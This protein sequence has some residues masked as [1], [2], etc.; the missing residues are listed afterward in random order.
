MG[1]LKNKASS[2]L[3]SQRKKKEK[4]EKEKRSIALG[5][6]EGEKKRDLGLIKL[7]FLFVTRTHHLKFFQLIIEQNLSTIS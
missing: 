1:F 4:K 6:L 7:E 2:Y 3:S 5:Y